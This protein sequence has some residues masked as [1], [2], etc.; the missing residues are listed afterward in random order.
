MK[1]D[2]RRNRSHDVFSRFRTRNPLHPVARRYK[3]FR[4][5]NSIAAIPQIMRV[6]S[7]T[8]SSLV[9]Y[10]LVQA[11]IGVVFL[12]VDSVWVNGTWL[13]PLLSRSSLTTACTM[14][15]HRFP[16][17]TQT[18]TIYMFSCEYCVQI[19]VQK[20]NKNNRPTLQAILQQEETIQYMLITLIF[21][22][23]LRVGKPTSHLREGHPMT[24]AFPV[25][26]RRSEK[27]QMIYIM[28]LVPNYVV[29]TQTSFPFISNLPYHQAAAGKAHHRQYERYD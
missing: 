22:N 6:Y 1:E 14:E 7:V 21:L 25:A 9:S 19:M 8:S 26:L 18:C 17:D 2:R 24:N 20:I 4:I 16:F 13:F 12:T 23:S 27:R 28:Q 29:S 10:P 11:L 5:G 15:L 3:P